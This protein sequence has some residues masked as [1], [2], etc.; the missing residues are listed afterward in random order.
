MTVSSERKPCMAPEPYWIL[1]AVP[2][3]LYVD[4]LDESYLV[5]MSHGT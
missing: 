2:F 4:D 1:K 5:W 3:T